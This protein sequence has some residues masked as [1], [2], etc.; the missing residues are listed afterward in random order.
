MKKLSP[1]VSLPSDATPIGVRFLFGLA[2]VV[3][4]YTTALIGCILFFKIPLT[5]TI[6]MMLSGIVLA[7]FLPTCV[8]RRLAFTQSSRTFITTNMFGLFLIVAI[9][10]AFANSNWMTWYI[11]PLGFQSTWLVLVTA[12]FHCG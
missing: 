12:Y 4:G 9:M 1:D 3:I 6:V 10:V 2:M 5:L 7:T 11:H 8:D